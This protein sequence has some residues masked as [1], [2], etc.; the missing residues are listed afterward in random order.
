[1]TNKKIQLCIVTGSLKGVSNLID[2]Q[3][4][5]YDTHVVYIDYQPGLYDTSSYFASYPI[6]YKAG[7]VL[8][9]M[10]LL[11][12]IT[13]IPT[14]TDMCK[15]V[16]KIMKN[17]KIDIIHAHWAIP[18]GF[19]S[20]MFA[21]H[22]PLVTTLRGLDAKLQLKQIVFQP[23]VSYALSRSSHVIAVSNKL[24]DEAIDLGVKK[25]KISVIPVGIDQKKFKHLDRKEIRNQLN[26]SSE[27]FIILFVGNLFKNK[28]VDRLLTICS[29]L[30]RDLKYR[31]IIIGSGQ[32]EKNL[33]NLADSLGI[34]NN[35]TFTGE[36]S[37]E[38]IPSYMSAS[39]VL[40]LLSKSEGLPGC[41]QE[42]MS[43]GIPVIASNVGGIPDIIRHERNGFLVSN[44]EEA[45][46]YLNQI[47][48]SP[49]IALQIGRN[50]Y[51]YSKDHLSL[52]KVVEETDEIY[53]TLL[54]KRS[55]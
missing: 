12:S 27:E 44:D 43:C 50:A 33:K 10:N 45:L 11:K 41:I 23:F 21:H 52:E 37:H 20:S 28:S 2:A 24:R 22:V 51:Q 48:S 19:I 14:L 47:I 39:D 40:F 7:T 31:V 17:N 53:G 4:K 55:N 25:N 26:L 30:K 32:E 46:A 29:N 34:L 35:V 13:I 8:A 42:A 15:Q 9:E 1:M 36:L 6:W 3:S 49:E 54:N 38:K 18:C 5:L 16:R